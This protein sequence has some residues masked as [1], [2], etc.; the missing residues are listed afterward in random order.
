MI[1][2]VMNFKREGQPMKNYVV[3]PKHLSGCYFL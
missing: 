3:D 1:V 2:E